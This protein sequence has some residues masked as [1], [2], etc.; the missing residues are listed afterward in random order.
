VWCEK[1]AM[2]YAYCHYK[3]RGSYLGTTITASIGCKGLASV[4][5]SICPVFFRTRGAYSTWL[6][7][8]QHATRPAYIYSPTIRTDRLV[9]V[10]LL[11]MLI[12]IW[13]NW[14]CKNENTSKPGEQ[15]NKRTDS[16]L[17]HGDCLEGKMGDY[18]TSSVLLCI[19][20]VHIM[21]TPI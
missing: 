6:T 10:A 17:S 4:R 9:T 7:R 11:L 14:N 21:C 8:G 13:P 19:I 2:H 16:Y 18:L 20:I 15:T 1:P 12:V 3:Q 5:P